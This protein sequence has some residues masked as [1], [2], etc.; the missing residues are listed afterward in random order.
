MAVACVG[1]LAFASISGVNATGSAPATGTI[2]DGNVALQFRLA[3]EGV[4]INTADS[5]YTVSTQG[6]VQSTK[7][8]RQ[9]SVSEAEAFSEFA[10]EITGTVASQAGSNNILVTCHGLFSTLETT[11]KGADGENAEVVS[12]MA[13]T[14]D[15][16]AFLTPG[17]PVVIA[18]SGNQ[19]LEL[20]YLP[21]P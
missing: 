2:L 17:K 1:V 3:G 10:I 13:C 14:I 16:S 11:S 20:T 8:T 12:E 4:V 7:G 21:T 18:R 5:V 9:N 15:A 19:E 6:H